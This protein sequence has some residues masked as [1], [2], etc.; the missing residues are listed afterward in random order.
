[1]EYI[2][3]H[4]CATSQ[5]TPYNIYYRIDRNKCNAKSMADHCADIE[6]ID[7]VNTDKLFEAIEV[8]F[9]DIIDQES[10]NEKQSNDTECLEL[11]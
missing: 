2:M 8:E 4:K 3:S 10:S 9:E 6:D 11:D 5:L 1:M 7:G